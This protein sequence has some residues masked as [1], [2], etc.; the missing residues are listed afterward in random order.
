MQYFQDMSVSTCVSVP[1]S[2]IIYFCFN[3]LGWDTVGCG[4]YKLWTF[5]KHCIIILLR[6]YIFTEDSIPFTLYQ[7]G[8]IRF[9]SNCF[10]I[11]LSLKGKKDLSYL[12]LSYISGFEKAQTG[13]GRC[14]FMK[15][16]IWEIFSG[17]R[18]KKKVCASGRQQQKWQVFL[19]ESDRTAWVF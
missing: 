11:L 4:N 19:Q 5:L 13:V 6:I 9:Y 3:E 15:L 17:W 12:F 7:F 10:C 2:K 1:R 16:Y 8:F 14:Y 18:L